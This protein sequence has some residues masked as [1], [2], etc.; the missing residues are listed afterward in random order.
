M[1]NNLDWL[2]KLPKEDSDQ[3]ETYLKRINELISAL[4]SISHDRNLMDRFGKEYLETVIDACNDWIK[5][6]HNEIWCIA[7]KKIVD[8]IS[9][10][11]TQKADI[12]DMYKNI[13][14]MD[15]K[16]YTELKSGIISKLISKPYSIER[17]FL[18][19]ARITKSVD[20]N[21]MLHERSV[22]AQ[23]RDEIMT[24]LTADFEEN[25]EFAKYMKAIKK[26]MEA[27]TF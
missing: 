23:K 24:K 4:D 25:S 19:L 18:N 6:I 1:N 7:L 10:E 21:D 9:L 12:Y 8:I 3:I 2:D 11:E 20:V 27:G 5:Q 13:K 14:V 26:N 17:R 16:I 22:I 15:E